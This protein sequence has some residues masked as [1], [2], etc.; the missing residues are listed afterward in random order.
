MPPE[1]KLTGMQRSIAEI[2]SE[3][4]VAPGQVAVVLEDLGV[5]HEQDQFDADDETLDLIKEA[6]KETGSSKTVRLAPG[7]APRDVAAAIGVA[8]KDVLK[9]MMVKLKVMATLTTTLDDEVTEKLAQ[10]FG[11][12]VVWGE[13][14]P[15]RPRASAAAKAVA[16]KT[17]NRPPVVTILGHVD[18]GK[19]SLL[20]YIRKTNVTAKEHGGITQHI[21]A[22]Q[23][24][25]KN[26]VIT[27]LDT[28]GHA[29][30]TAMRARG[31]QVTDIAIL[32]VA[33]DDGIMPQTI[34][35]ISHAKSAEVP[36]I[37]AINKIDVQGANPDRVLQQLPKYELVPE[38]FG[39]QVI[40]CKV[41][42]LTGEGVDNL[43][44][45]ILLQAEVMDLK[46][47]PKGDL[48][49]VVIEAQLEK[50]R[51]PVA[52]VLVE[53]GS[54]KVGDV[55][56]VGNTW[57]KVK[58]MSDWAGERL[59]EAG[60]SMPAEV[61]GLNE[62]PYAGDV[63]E[64]AKD[65]REAREKADARVDSDR[66]IE[67]KPT[68]R[69]VSLKDLVTAGT[70]DGVKDLNLIIKAD[71]QGSVEAVRGMLEKLEHPEVSVRILHT[72][73]GAITESDIL[74]ASAARAIVVGFNV[75]PE[76]N[77]KY[78]AERQK[79]ETRT[80]K[81]IYELVEDIEKAVKGLLEPKFEEEYL[82]TVEVRA[83]FKLT[84]AGIVAGCHVT[85]GRVVR[86]AS[87][88]VKRDKEIAYTGKIS[89]LR[90]VKEDVRE[91]A[92]GQD[93][94]VRFENWTE[95]KAGDVIEAFQMIQV[96]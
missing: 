68:R 9:T 85:D 77:A 41:S 8:D 78:E 5:L 29:A 59:K 25:V 60:P 89:S 7:R 17:E 87:C 81:I 52:T 27:F 40:T 93:C 63:V 64:P 95:F 67:F 13:A 44:E 46:C 18:H 72:G 73:V 54:L 36:I 55:I 61:L 96:N 28:P 14:P 47:D 65:E 16:A 24:K 57:G 58:A 31:A 34:E 33:A 71:V 6:V 26:G 62:V 79:V 66:E 19:T 51:G 1:V 15:P 92:A 45:M 56:V 35:A 84:K 70:D 20:D 30:F 48:E 39:G 50:G 80:Y 82:G 91:M 83:V 88:R 4:G 2:A 43:L 10:E 12:K 74:L 90:N 69:K 42:A 86:G 38:A 22:Y 49:G 32:V 94:G 3:F 75:K 37:I 53:N 11:Y 76:G 21:G 23:V